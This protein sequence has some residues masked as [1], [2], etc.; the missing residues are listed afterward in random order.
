ME[1]RATVPVAIRNSEASDGRSDFGSVAHP[2]TD[3]ANMIVNRSLVEGRASQFPVEA[4]HPS[5]ISCEAILYLRSI[6]PIEKLPFCPLVHQD[7]LAG[8]VDMDRPSQ[9]SRNTTSSSGRRR[10]GRNVAP[11][12][13]LATGSRQPW[14]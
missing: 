5:D 1:S 3:E 6:Q 11:G 8:D 4:V 12:R 13:S 14:T 7:S 2:I 9:P 10:A